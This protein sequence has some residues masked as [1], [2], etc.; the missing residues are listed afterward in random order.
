[1]SLWNITSPDYVPPS[2][3]VPNWVWSIAGWG[4]NNIQNSDVIVLRLDYVLVSSDGKSYTR[5]NNFRPGWS[6]GACTKYIPIFFFLFEGSAIS[7]LSTWSGSYDYN[8]PVDGSAANYLWKNYIY[9]FLYGIRYSEGGMR[10]YIPLQGT[11]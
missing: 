1:M 11:T 5:V 10:A 3:T 2:T 7:Y 9:K 6:S 8:L 4:R